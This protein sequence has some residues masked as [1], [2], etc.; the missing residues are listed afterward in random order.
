MNWGRE[1][2]RRGKM[3]WQIASKEKRTSV[4]QLQELCSVNNLNKFRIGLFPEY[5]EKKHKQANTFI[6]AL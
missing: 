4:L 5:P 2:L 1:V 6:L 3:F